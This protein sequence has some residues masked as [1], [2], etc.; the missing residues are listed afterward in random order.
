MKINYLLMCNILLTCT[1]LLI[2][3]C[4]TKKDIHYMQD[5]DD[6]SPVDLNYSENILQVDDILKISVEALVPEAALPYNKISPTT[7]QV[8]NL[9]LSMLEG[10]L[11]SKDLTIN[12]PVLGTISVK[13]K[14]CLDLEK[15]LKD[16]LESGGHLINPTVTVRLLNSKVTILGEVNAPGT[17]TFSEN[18]ISLLQA[19]GL[20]GDLTIN[21]DREDVIVIRTIDGVQNSAHLNLTTANWF[22]G[23]YHSIKPNDVIIVKPN[24]TKVKTAGYVG[25]ASVVLSIVST[26]LSAIILITN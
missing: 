17:Y 23:P 8:T 22:D 7:S 21:G 12:F 15:H 10:Y 19:I 25:D 5:L 4:V 13:S 11:V 3:S 16:R 14:T 26:L 20:A 24:V 18:K 9:E 6:Y 2:N 1:I